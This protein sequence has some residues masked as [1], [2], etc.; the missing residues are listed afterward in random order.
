MA[1]QLVGKS[2]HAKGVHWSLE[3]PSTLVGRSSDCDVVLSD[4]TVSRR[5]CE[6]WNRDNQLT[7]VNLSDANIC[8]V[9]GVPSTTCPVAAGDEVAIGVST[10]FITQ[11]SEGDQ[12][13]SQG[14]SEAK[15]TAI[16]ELDSEYEHELIAATTGQQDIRT[17]RDLH[18]LYML[19]L[20]LG[21]I[22]SQSK[23][24]EIVHDF[25]TK[26]FDG[27][28]SAVYLADGRAKDGSPNLWLAA[29]SDTDGVSLQE[30][31]RKS[32]L[33]NEP[34]LQRGAIEGDNGSL[35]A[36]VLVAPMAVRGES[37]GV[38]LVESQSEK[39]RLD[40][41]DLNFLSALG[42]TACPHLRAMGRTACRHLHTMPESLGIEEECS[43]LRDNQAQG[44]NLIGDS[45]AI[46]RVRRSIRQAARTDLSTLILGET[47]TGKELVA[48]LI[49]EL[50]G[51]S[52]GRY[53]V[54]NCPAI[55]R[56]LF[57]SQLFGHES[58][59]FTGARER[60]IG[61]VEQADGGTLFFDEIADLSLSHQARVLR[62]LEDG[63]FRRVGG[64]TDI[65]VHFRSIAATNK[66]LARAVESG[67]FREDLYHRINAFEIQMP[68]LRKRPSDVP[69][70]AEEFLRRFAR[71][72]GDQ[73]LRL[74]AEAAELLKT[75]PF[76]GNVRELKNRVNRAA[77]M[78]RDRD[79]TISDFA[80]SS[81][82]ISRPE[83]PPVVSSLRE[84][85]K[86]H[87]TAVLRD[88]G[89]KVSEAA[90]R[91]EV[92]RSTL[93]KKLGDHG[94]ST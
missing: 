26:S 79:L 27:C 81:S 72:T 4:E 11:G 5:H 48:R 53:I 88:C 70:L 41:R 50:G 84:A 10:F 13:V 29:G 65:Q 89:G 19:S 16:F 23:A 7:L 93:Y 58:G 62:V 82:S 37:F 36:T 38:L 20:T 40:E 45:R 63:V 49:H 22:I 17:I 2:G 61:L 80:T 69:L 9:N 71:V 1:F 3:S 56:E 78:A 24:I 42:R 90:K 74:S 35:P 92:S 83:S 43:F 67:A 47:G 30:L 15:T 57:E 60:H 39:A 87:I 54:V 34:F 75:M 44:F 32:F 21:D 46:G 25:T 31:M 66:D 85:E 55:P 51:E 86:N 59:A 12:P 52:I 91:L 6:F 14:V 77:S 76:R 73:P 18:E 8:L 33:E 94:I 28:R 64:A 68:P